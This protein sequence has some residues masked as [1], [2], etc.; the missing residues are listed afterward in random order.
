MNKMDRIKYDEYFDKVDLYEG[1]EKKHSD[2]TT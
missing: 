1:L 2:N